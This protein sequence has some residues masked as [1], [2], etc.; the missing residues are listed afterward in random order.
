MVDEQPH[1]R[2]SVETF[3]FGVISLVSLPGGALLC[4]LGFRGKL[5]DTSDGENLISGL[6][7]LVIG[8]VPPALTLA[9]WVCDR[10]PVDRRRGFEVEQKRDGEKSR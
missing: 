2:L 7:F 5:A 8:I 3:V 1:D 6:A 10:R 4:W 9:S